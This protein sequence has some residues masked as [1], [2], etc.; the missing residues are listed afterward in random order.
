MPEGFLNCSLHLCGDNPKLVFTEISEVVWIT[1]NRNT[2]IVNCR[3]L[4]TE[5][6]VL[7]TQQHTRATLT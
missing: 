7:S 6:P 3:Y 5:V 2:C 4:M 1:I